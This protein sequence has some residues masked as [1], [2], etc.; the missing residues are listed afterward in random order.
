MVVLYNHLHKS[1]STEASLWQAM[2][3]KKANNMQKNHKRDSVCIFTNKTN[4]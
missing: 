1:L 2:R 3:Q 4:K